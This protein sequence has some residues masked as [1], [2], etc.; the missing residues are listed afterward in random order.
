MIR[1]GVLLALVAA[2]ALLPLRL[3]LGPGVAAAEVQ[4]TVWRGRLVDAQWNGLGLGDVEVGVGLPALL[5]G[6][7]ALR[8][9]G[10][11]TG[12]VGPGGVA[13]LSGRGRL[14]AGGGVVQMEG[15]TLLF[16]QGRC[17]E[18]AGR[19]VL[20]QGGETLA[21]TPRCAGEAAEL[22][23]ARPDGVVAMTMKVPAL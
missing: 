22:A 13:G 9:S 18:T 12:A 11:V 7:P 17:V 15:L 3:V 16:S 10:G 2:V 14:L 21:G 6:A 20:R 23:M 5:R 19:L 8:V 1:L 4:G